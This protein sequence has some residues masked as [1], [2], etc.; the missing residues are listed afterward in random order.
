MLVESRAVATI[1]GD[2]LE[3][4]ARPPGPRDHASAVPEPSPALERKLC[5]VVGLNQN[6]ASA[7]GTLY[8]I[9]IEDLGPVQDRVTERE[10]RRVNVIVYANYGEPNARIIHS[11]D[12]DFDDVRTHTHN[13]LV[14]QRIQGL[15]EE[16]RRTI[17]DKEQ[18]LVMRIKCLIREY[19]YTKDEA[20]KKE[21]EQ[22][23][24]MYPFLFS[25]AW[26]ELKQERPKSE[27]AAAPPPPA[28]VEDLVPEPPPEVL[29]PLD[30]ELRARVLDIERIIKELTADLEELRAR[31]SADD[32][33]L[34]TC[35]KLVTRARESLTGQ[36]PTDFTAR[37]LEMT[38]NSLVTTWKQVRSRLMAS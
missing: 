13:Q 10:V 30:S 20:A 8:H 26:A 9:Q 3:R 27:G 11:E 22:A 37:R 24:A 33:L 19:F 7:A 2:S 18:R 1:G 25:R 4:S 38:R 31:G 16:A 28:A 6:Y 12:H 5:Q 35:R 32:I 36:E 34:Q 23:N 21:F 14:A 15:A 17:E 29:Y